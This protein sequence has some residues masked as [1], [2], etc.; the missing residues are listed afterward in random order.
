MEP[1]SAAFSEETISKVQ[2]I[3]RKYLE[4]KSL[5]LTPQREQILDYFLHAEWHLSS[6]ELY[7][8]I[9][10]LNPKIG[11]STVYRTLRLLCDAG[12]AREL[13]LGDER[14]HFEPLYKVAHHDHLICKKCGKVI[15]FFCEEIEDLQEK[16]CAEHDFLPE[17]HTHEIYGLCRN[18]RSGAPSAPEAEGVAG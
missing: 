15:E 4:R 17:N 12:L 16:I 5:R 7:R 2:E 6:E 9:R 13:P 11:Y 14:S 18:C 10:R 8:Q 1:F 3:F